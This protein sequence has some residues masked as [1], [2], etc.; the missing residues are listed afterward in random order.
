[1]A[2]IVEKNSKKIIKSLVV[3]IYYC[4]MSRKLRMLTIT[5]A[6]T[7]AICQAKC[8]PPKNFFF[9]ILLYVYFTRHEAVIKSCSPLNLLFLIPY[10]IVLVFN[11]TLRNIL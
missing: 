8:F 11:Y 5:I 1:M 7:S 3:V 2:T 9:F 6:E 4:A 10:L